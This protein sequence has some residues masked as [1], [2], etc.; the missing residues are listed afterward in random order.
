MLDYHHEERDANHF[1]QCFALHMC[2]SS[3]STVPN[4]SE[5]PSIT[6]PTTAATSQCS[7]NFP[8]TF[9]Q[10]SGSLGGPDLEEVPPQGD[11]H[12]AIWSQ[13]LLEDLYKLLPGLT[14]RRFANTIRTNHLTASQRH[15]II[16]NHSTSWRHLRLVTS[17]TISESLISGVSSD[18]T[19]QCCLNSCQNIKDIK[20]TSSV[21]IFSL[22]HVT[23]S[24]QIGKW[25][26]FSIHFCCDGYDSHK[27]GSTPFPNMEGTLNKTV[28]QYW[29]TWV[30]KLRLA[31]LPPVKINSSDQPR[32]LV[33]KNVGDAKEILNIS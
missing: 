13:D 6:M 5:T 18:L 2:E 9:R 12:W 1:S 28:D 27:E 33:E 11:Q 16:S 19:C 22:R 14:I 26:A 23:T 10:P 31:A 4:T 7:D 15:S 3:Q 17:L 32:C 21:L 25:P 30:L 29:S 24:F 8:T 20:G